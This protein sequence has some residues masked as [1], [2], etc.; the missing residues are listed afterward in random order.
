MSDESLC[1]ASA[2][3]NFSYCGWA[4]ESL[5]L[6]FFSWRIV[7]VSVI[8]LSLFLS[9]L[10]SSRLLRQNFESLRVLSVTLPFFKK[11]YFPCRK[12]NLV[13]SSTPDAT[14]Q[15][16]PAAMSTSIRPNPVLGLVTDVVDGAIMTTKSAVIPMFRSLQ[17]FYKYEYIIKTWSSFLKCKLKIKAH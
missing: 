9:I 11:I 15:I 14:E 16:T 13:R 5:V 1:E 17:Q 8:L 10:F 7:L 2:F 3:G 4:G 12:V 6:F